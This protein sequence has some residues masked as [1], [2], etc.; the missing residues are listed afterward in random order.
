MNQQD[1]ACENN[2][3]SGCPPLS[4]YG[5]TQRVLK[6]SED[7]DKLDAKMGE[8]IKV[9][10][11]YVND[12]LTGLHDKVDTVKWQMDQYPA[13]EWTE[14][15]NERLN[16]MGV[17]ICDWELQLTRLKQR[18]ENLT[19]VVTNEVIL[20]KQQSEAMEQ[21]MEHWGKIYKEKLQEF[22]EKL[23]NLPTRSGDHPH[24]PDVAALQKLTQD[25]GAFQEGW[26]KTSEGYAT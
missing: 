12:E 1:S 15:V 13:V 7:L 10:S 18:R 2:T 5:L 14:G 11:E 17:Q 22:E 26:K 16:T 8:S 25:F 19:Q 6:F 24:T 23:Q 20:A 3:D 21:K 9:Y 4:P